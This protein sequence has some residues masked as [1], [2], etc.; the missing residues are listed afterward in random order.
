MSDALPLHVS[1]PLGAQPSGVDSAETT[2]KAAEQPE[3]KKNKHTIFLAVACA[4]SVCISSYLWLKLSHIQE[5]LARQSADSSAQSVEART[6]AR[7][8]QELAQQTAARQS[9]MDTRLSEVAL[10]RGQLDELIQSLSRSRD[11]N[12]VVDIESA[13][14]LAQQQVQ[15]TGSLEPMLA[16]LKSAD[17]RLVRAAQPRLNPLQRALAKDLD[18]VKAVATVDMLG[19]LVKLDELVR[20]VEELP[21]GNKVGAVKAPEP[22]KKSASLS[23]VP[24]STFEDAAI[25]ESKYAL[26]QWIS[27][28]WLAFKEEARK[29]VRVSTIAS[30]DAI[31]LSPEQSFFIRENLKLRLLNARLG[32]LA[33]QIEASRADLVVVSVA[34]D[35]YFDSS[36]RSTQQ[37]SILVQQLQ[38]QLRANELPRIDDTLAAL[39]TA[40]AGR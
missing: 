40:A 22:V 8:A 31:L 35:K 25:N 29:L 20:L 1:P 28:V 37:A 3:A 23:K 9:S 18:R 15:L 38:S 24:N 39:A 14:R 32:M 5:T 34:L 19:L 33:R 11:E 27:G 12:L 7:T 6:L 13:L 26:P 36:A 30:P 2:Y 17:Q 16:A 10:Q 4:I 21:L